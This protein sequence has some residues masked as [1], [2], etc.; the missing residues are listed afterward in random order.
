[1]SKNTPE[2]TEG[3]EIAQ[4]DLENAS[5]GRADAYATGNA[6]IFPNSYGSSGGSGGSG[7]GGGAGGGYLLAHELTHVA[8]QG[9]SGGGSGNNRP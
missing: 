5:G 4:E 1:M 2:T 6:P 3:K 7:G 9:S 8:N